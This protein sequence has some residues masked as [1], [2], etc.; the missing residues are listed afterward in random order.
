MY[1]NLQKIK[2]I[3]IQ[4]MMKIILEKI[5]IDDGLDKKYSNKGK[6]VFIRTVSLRDSWAKLKNK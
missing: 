2:K 5:Y 3:Y 1:Q 4:Y 6:N